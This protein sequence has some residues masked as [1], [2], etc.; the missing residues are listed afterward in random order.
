[1][2]SD[3]I[4]NLR[5]KLQK[6][7]RRLNSLEQCFFHGGLRQFWGFLR[8]HSSFQGILD[9]LEA[10]FPGAPA[11]CKK[12]VEEHVDILGET[13]TEHAAISYCILRH[14]A[15]VG[16]E[17]C[18]WQIGH[19]YTNGG[20]GMTGTFE[21]F[22][23]LFLEPF[24]EYLDEQLDDQ[25]AILALLRRYKLK[26]EWFKR[27]ELHKQWSDNTQRGEKHLAM[28][29]YEYLHDQGMDFTIEP[30]SV[31]GK[32]D[33]VAAQNTDDPLIADTKVFNPAKGQGKSYIVK[34]FAQVYRYTVD[35][36]EP[37]GY[38]IVYLTGEDDLR[39]A[40]NHTSMSTPFVVHNNKTI[41]LLTIDICPH[42]KSASKRGALQ[43]V[44]I[45]E[46]D[47]ICMANDAAAAPPSSPTT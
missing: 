23:V 11:T 32:A 39:F 28:H 2:N 36:N 14:C 5:Y 21:Q 19:A 1:M 44:E 22:R 29:L 46:A 20:G 34:G 4:Q 37:F 8:S 10:R 15:T 27:D 43:P 33:L 31:S 12:I 25:K 7:V 3:Y 16:D 47:M 40:L 18:E 42:E 24:Y 13:E 30:S 6:R 38:L 45:T 9:D 41:F 17:E 26:C 35:F